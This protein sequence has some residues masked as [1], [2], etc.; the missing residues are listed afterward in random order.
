MC[1]QFEFS[2]LAEALLRLDALFMSM[3]IDADVEEGKEP[4]FLERKGCMY[5]RNHIEKAFDNFFKSLHIEVVENS[6]HACILFEGGSLTVVYEND[7]YDDL[8]VREIEYK[9]G[10]CRWAHYPVLDFVENMEILSVTEESDEAGKELL[11]EMKQ[12][13][14]SKEFRDELIEFRG[15]YTK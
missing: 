9:G 8:S 15:R 10:R 14:R 3:V 7:D 2:P 6:L 13:A 5:L 4:L 1:A 12:V 11:H